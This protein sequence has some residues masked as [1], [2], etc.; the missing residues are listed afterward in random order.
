MAQRYGLGVRSISLVFLGGFTEIDSETRTPG[1][2]F[3]VAVVGPLTSIAVGLV[4]IPL[5]LIT[6]GGLL[7]FTVGVTFH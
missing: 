3:K 4:F 6:P 5:W 7:E 1:Q 2:E